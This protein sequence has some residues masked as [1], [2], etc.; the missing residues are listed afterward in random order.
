M[1]KQKIYP[2][3]QISV[4]NRHMS[5]WDM[6]ATWIGANANNG[7]WYIVKNLKFF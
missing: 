4:E 6:F 5:Y 7:T 2:I 1:E 3:E